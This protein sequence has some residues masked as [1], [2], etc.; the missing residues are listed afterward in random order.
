MVKENEKAKVNIH[1]KD[2]EVEVFEKEG[3]VYAKTHINNFGEIL[4]PD[5]GGGRDRALENIKARI[6][7]IVMAMQMDETRE[8][9]RKQ[10]E[11]EAQKQENQNS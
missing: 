11:Q 6:G 3:K 2:F 4:V 9:R 5:F 1:E 10:L 7:N 8:T